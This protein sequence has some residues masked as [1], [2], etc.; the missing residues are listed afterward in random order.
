MAIEVHHV[1]SKLAVAYQL[2][3][4]PGVSR[5]IPDTELL[6]E[7]TF[8]KMIRKHDIV[9]LKPDRGRK[10]RGVI[11]IE[12]LKKDLFILR[13]GTEKTYVRSEDL[14]AKV[15]GMTED[16]KYII[17]RAVNSVTKDGRPFD[18]RCHSL[19]V[20]GRWKVGGICGR[21]GEKGSIVTTSHYGGTPTLLATLF[22]RHLGLTYKER[23]KLNRKL[24]RCVVK[25]VRQVSHMFPNLYEFA[26]DI[27]IDPHNRIW[28]YEVNIEPLIRGNFKLLPDQTLYRK[29]KRMREI[30]R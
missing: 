25:T 15:K 28:I 22:K 2:I 4:T 6:R 21:L 1:K 30:A 3:H 13:E 11:R 24:E 8:Y 18:L 7:S 5:H 14:W 17:Q 9:Y 27:G 10:S 16:S 29:I 12:K 23:T 20:N 19:R 26:V